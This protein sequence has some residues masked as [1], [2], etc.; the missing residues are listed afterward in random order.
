M[1]VSIIIPTFKR[2]QSMLR[3]LK[4]LAPELNRDVEI[5]ICEQQFNNGGTFLRFA[6]KHNIN[7]RYYLKPG[8]EGTSAAKNYA[9]KKSK[10]K[11]IIFFDDDVKVSKGVVF[12]LI[13]PLANKKIGAVGGR[14]I[15]PGQNVDEH[16]Y[17][18][19]KITF[20]GRFTDGFS[21]IVSQEIDTVIGC[22]CAWRKSVF[23]KINGFDE[24]F[25]GAIREDSD[26]SLR[27][28]QLGKK[29]I[30][31]PNALVYH[32]RDPNGGGRKTE[33]RIL[34]YKNFFSNET[35]FFLKHRPLI[36]LP[37]ILLTRWEW[38]L[39]CMFGF[40]REVSLRS[41][42]TPFAGVIDGFKKYEKHNYWG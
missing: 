11:Y 7:L 14:V 19:G 41:I 10:G 15:T 12:N 20:F 32:L 23:N 33:G 13:A 3:L 1:K 29:I 26:I 37:I 36:I 8:P 28:K 5:I 16:N 6:K 40:G 9:V 18:V 4:S 2:K 21:S 22:N 25:T 34:W 38:A 39:R 42:T 31:E 30:F 24:N 35:Y 17:N 27:T